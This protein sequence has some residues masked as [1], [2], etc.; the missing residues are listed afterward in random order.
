M[1]C[2]LRGG[3]TDGPMIFR[4]L[5]LL[6]LSTALVAGCFLVPKERKILEPP[7]IDPPAVTYRTVE[8]TR[9]VIE[10]EV[11]VTG[12]YEYTT[13]YSLSFTYKG[14]RLERL[15]VRYGD[16]V[17]VGRLVAEL[18]AGTLLTDIELQKI[19]VERA[20][21]ILTKRRVQDDRLD[22]RLAELDLQAARIRL[23]DLQTALERRR[24]YSPIDGRVVYIAPI[25]IGDF[26]EPYEVV[27]RI[28]DPGEML[29]IYRGGE[30][31]L[32]KV[33]YPV[34]LRVGDETYQGVVVM[35]PATAPAR[36]PESQRNRVF[37]RPVDVSPEKLERSFIVIR[38]VIARK[39]NVIVVPRSGVR[40]YQNRYFVHVLENNIRIERPVEIGM[41]TQTHTEILEGLAEGELII[42]Q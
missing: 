24:I 39:E 32:F 27:A 42:L 18:E 9:G 8:V 36:L 23:R 13:Q 33:D 1:D 30:A 15:P 16:D 41:E 4:R 7:L 12:T 14:G 37:I 5:L 34:E 29:V 10:Q 20:E 17:T 19:A 31:G 28:A 26:V 40:E 21:I 25:E 38:A 22:V 2:R 11:I 3:Y 35:T 6:S